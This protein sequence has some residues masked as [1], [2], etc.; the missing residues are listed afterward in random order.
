MKKRIVIVI[1]SILV[2][3][4]YTPSA[5]ACCLYYSGTW[6]S[7]NRLTVHVYQSAEPFLQ[8]ISPAVLSWN[9]ISSKVAFISIQGGS[10]S[11]VSTHIRIK[12]VDFDTDEFTANCSNYVTVL[13]VTVPSWSGTWAYS[14]NRLNVTPW[15]QCSYHRILDVHKKKVAA[16]ELGHSLGIRHTLSS[17]PD[18]FTSLMAPYYNISSN[19]WYAPQTHDENVL[20]A[21]YGN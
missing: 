10:D 15:Y 2:V 5:I 7:P 18:Y 9:G 3:L 1:L 19:S 17:C 6:S 21:K 14:E 4:I 20:R 11:G 16:Y 8:H 12:A 13:G